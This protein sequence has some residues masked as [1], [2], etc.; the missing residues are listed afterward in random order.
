MPKRSENRLWWS[1][2]GQV[3]CTRHRPEFRSRVWTEE[4]WEEIPSE[5][6]R[7]RALSCEACGFSP[8]DVRKAEST[9]R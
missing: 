4:E 3:A 8:S 2:L 7:T 6:F 5:A 1:L 9:A